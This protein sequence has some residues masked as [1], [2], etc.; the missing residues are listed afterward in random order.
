MK[1][2]STEVAEIFVCGLPDEELNT[3]MLVA[4]VVPRNVKIAESKE[5]TAQFIVKIQELLLANINVEFYHPRHWFV[6][7]S[8]PKTRT[9]KFNRIAIKEMVIK[10]LKL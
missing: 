6:F 5:E 9:R 2:L 1:I 8:L 10:A 3:M 7:S 4:V